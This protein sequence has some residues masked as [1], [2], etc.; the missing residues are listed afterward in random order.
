VSCAVLATGGISYTCDPSISGITCST[1]NTT[2]AGL[3]NTTFT[4]LNANIYIQYGTT[5]LGESTTGFENQISYAD[6]RA[7]LAATASSDAV[8]TAALAS[9][10]VTEP[11]LYD[12]APVEITSALGTALGLT[13]LNGTTVGG[14][15]CT[16]GV[17]GCYNGIITITNDPST[18]LYYRNGVQNPDSYDFFSVVEHET[19]E[20]L[21]TASCIDTT[22]ASLANGC[23]NN[24]ASA[25]DLFRYNAGALVFIDTTL[26]AYFS[27]DGGATNGAGG[28]VYNT[29]ANGND[30]AD[31]LTGCPTSP[32]VQD[33]TGCPGFGGLD[34]T[35]DGGAEIT[36]L[37]AVG[38][39][40]NPVP[41]PGT[42]ALLAVGLAFLAVMRQTLGMKSSDPPTKARARE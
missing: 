15:L 19:D 3:Y 4:N 32:R 13:N 25:V 17:P 20:V 31:F 38:Y 26:G 7:D 27:Y 1:L 34:I 42:T 41:E 37:D 30:Y 6:Y 35:N 39:N 23:G 18:L 11:A 21:G 12:G 5:G 28:A 2:V 16:V 8:D 14:S 40:L 10:P 36:I 9:L 22:G 33:G 24:A 29:L